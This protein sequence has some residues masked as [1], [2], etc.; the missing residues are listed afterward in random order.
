MYLSAHEHSYERT[1][2]IYDGKCQLGYKNSTAF[3]LS[4]LIYP[5]NVIWCWWMFRGTQSF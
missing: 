1:C 5:I 2:P 4:D 3:N